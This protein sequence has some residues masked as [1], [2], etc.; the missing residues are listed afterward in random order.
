[1]NHIYR[2]VL[3]GTL[4]THQ[5]Y[6]F[7]QLKVETVLTYPFMLRQCFLEEHDHEDDIA[8]GKKESEQSWCNE[9]HAFLSPGLDREICSNH[10]PD[11]ETH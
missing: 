4:F 2:T 1:M 7:S 3:H 8:D 9:K 5:N 10:W 6:I 11:K